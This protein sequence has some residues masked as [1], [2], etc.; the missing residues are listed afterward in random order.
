M[1]FQL[2]VM[3]SVR[4]GLGDDLSEVQNQVSSG[5]PFVGPTAPP[6]LQSL[7]DGR[8]NSALLRRSERFAKRRVARAE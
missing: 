6:P 2:D 7:C 4:W 8:C 3:G 5:T 1:G